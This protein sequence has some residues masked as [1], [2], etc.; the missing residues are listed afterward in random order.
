MIRRC[1][2]HLAALAP[3]LWVPG[4]ANDA[5]EDL[6]VLLEPLLLHGDEVR[7]CV[8][9]SVR[10]VMVYPRVLLKEEILE[11]CHHCRAHR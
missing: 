3:R 7:A 4:I 8:N 11:T 1:E 6:A 2:A 5:F 9:R 10:H